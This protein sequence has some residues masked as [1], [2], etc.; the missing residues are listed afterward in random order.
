MALAPETIA[1][2][3]ATR[4][5]LRNEREAI[6]R[7]IDVINTNIANWQAEKAKLIARRT[8]INAWLASMLAD[9]PQATDEEGAP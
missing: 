9:I 1:A 2:T 5:T 4:R 6:N 8:E 7:E 3:K